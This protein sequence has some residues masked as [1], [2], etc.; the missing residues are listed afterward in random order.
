MAARI[1]ESVAKRTGEGGGIGREARP[2]G[3]RLR[4]MRADDLE[5]V[6]GIERSSFTNPW[7]ERT[8][9]SLL[10]RKDAELW[11]AELGKSGVVGYLVLWFASEEGELADLAVAEG[12]R[13]RGIGSLLLSRAVELAREHGVRSLFLEVRASNERAAALYRSRGFEVMTVRRDYYRKPTEDALVMFK[14]LW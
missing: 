7:K 3:L 1:P 6:V 11:V 8:F 5:R 13:G 12:E 4:P 14:S 10:P 9:R 2:D